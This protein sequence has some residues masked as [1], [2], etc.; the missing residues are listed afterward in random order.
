MSHLVHDEARL[1]SRHLAAEHRHRLRVLLLHLGQEV[2]RGAN[3]QRVLG[4]EGGVDDLSDRLVG[5][6]GAQAAVQ[7]A[8]DE[9]IAVPQPRLVNL[10]IT[11]SIP[12]CIV[13]P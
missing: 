1:E 9:P 3:A 10:N 6:G 11:V 2:E 12:F 5:R 7:R 4:I 13:T 8:L